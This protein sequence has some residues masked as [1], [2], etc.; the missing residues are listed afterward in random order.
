MTPNLDK[1]LAIVGNDREGVRDDPTKNLRAIAAFWTT[2]LRGR[3]LLAEGAALAAGDA[4]YMMALL[5]LARLSND[6]RHADSKS[7]LYGYALLAE[8]CDM[9][10]DA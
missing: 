3:G 5:K 1:A 10:N 9:E 4:A 2:W 8:L 6:P 7:D